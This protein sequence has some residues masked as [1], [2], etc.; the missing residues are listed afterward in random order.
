MTDT[1][2]EFIVDFNPEH[3]R[4]NCTIFEEITYEGEK[5]EVIEKS[6][7]DKVLQDL[8][9]E[10]AKVDELLLAW[11]NTSMLIQRMS[12]KKNIEQ[13]Q[14]LYRQGKHL[15]YSEVLRTEKA[16]KETEGNK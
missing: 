7:Y 9:A 12:R 1:P 8:E 14:D 6:A 13:V 10:K 5:I 4:F 2:R 16:L 15:I 11:Q 3:V